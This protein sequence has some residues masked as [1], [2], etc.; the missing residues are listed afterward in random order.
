MAFQE[1]FDANRA[2]FYSL[3]GQVFFILGLAIA[4]SIRRGTEVPL[5]RPLWLLSAFGFLH[6][7]Y[8]W[9]YVVLPIQ[10][11]YLAAETYRGLEILQRPLEALSF[12]FLL[13]FG[14]E[15]VRL[16][17]PRRW[18]RYAP[19][20]ILV[21]WLAGYF[22]ALPPLEQNFKPYS[23]LADLWARYLLCFPGAAIAAY[24]LLLQVRQA[25]EAGVQQIEGHLRGAALSFLLYG[26]VAGLL[27]PPASF[28]PA[29]W[30]NRG[31][32]SS[33]L[34]IPPPVARM[35]AGIL[36]TYFIIRSLRIFEIEIK[37]LVE[38]ARRSQALV[39][40]RERISR[41][42]H[43]G[44]VQNLYGAGLSLESA[45]ATLRQDARSAE[46]LIGRAIE[47]LKHC[48][49]EIRNYIFDLAWKEEIDYEA[50]L[51]DLVERMPVPLQTHFEVTG[52][53]PKKLPPGVSLHLYHIL[54]EATTNVQ[55]H[56]QASRV[57][58]TLAYGKDEL[59][60]SID[61]DG[62]GFEPENAWRPSHPWQQGLK[63]MKRR[64]ELLGGKVAIETGAGK[65][66]RVSLT[67]P[68]KE[69]AA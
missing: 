65:G 18:L 4:L 62:V 51:R 8:E 25:K 60:A 17:R 24:G 14:A 52:S 30:V 38:D 39:Q 56:A 27:V 1:L 22:Y 40:E 10:K 29:S 32:L 42:L 28:F 7:F 53:R 59:T 5:A 48:M 31:L 21:L 11:S 58:V 19:S 13:Q 36:V 64:V 67:V 57:R 33:Y 49:V 20:F 6:G 34:G 35:L 41:E 12:F 55:R 46:A 23:N 43:D 61:D 44:I 26:I 3:Y 63:N 45:L 47:S 54:Q 2:L 50:K 68:L 16:S 15:V 69:N 66:T 37:R 9:S